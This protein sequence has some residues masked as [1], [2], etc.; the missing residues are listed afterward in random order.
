MTTGESW[1]YLMYDL[2]ARPSWAF[3]CT[4]APRWSDDPP[5][6]CG[7]PLAAQALLLSFTLLVSFIMMNLFVAVVLGECARAELWGWHCVVMW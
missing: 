4:D 7:N 3:N 6:G 1:T 5:T 2:S